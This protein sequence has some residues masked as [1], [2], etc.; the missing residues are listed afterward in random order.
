LLVLLVLPE[1]EALWLSQ[2]PEELVLRHCAYWASLV[3]AEPTTATSSVR[4]VIPRSQVFSVQAVQTLM[5]SLVQGGL[6]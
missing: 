2:S 5:N 1:D 4:I 3:G 6:P